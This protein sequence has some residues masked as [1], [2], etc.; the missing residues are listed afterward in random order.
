M[1]DLMIQKIRDY[2]S[3]QPAVEKAWLFGS[4]ARGEQ[5]PQS[6]VDVLVEYTAGSK[7][8]LL[9]RATMTYELEDI[10]SK[11]VDLVKN[12]TLLPFAIPS[13]EHDKHLIYERSK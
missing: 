8:S 3:T 13:V 5:T 10:L 2:F 4:Y 7:V 11:R 1:P 6:D 12:G 9:G